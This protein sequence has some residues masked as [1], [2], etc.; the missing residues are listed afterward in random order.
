MCAW[1]L[2]HSGLECEHYHLF[3]SFPLF[4]PS[5]ALGLQTLLIR[6]IDGICKSVEMASTILHLTVRLVVAPMPACQVAC[7]VRTATACIYCHP[8][9]CLP[10]ACLHTCKH[11]PAICLTAYTPAAGT[12]L[13]GGTAMAG[14][15]QYRHSPTSKTTDRGMHVEVYTLEALLAHAPFPQLPALHCP[16]EASCSVNFVVPLGAGMS[17]EHQCC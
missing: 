17:H 16:Q 8:F 4:S 12:R 9:S 6:C 2:S 7:P 5:M 14:K 15:L 3:Y 1:F 13:V 11:L 10:H